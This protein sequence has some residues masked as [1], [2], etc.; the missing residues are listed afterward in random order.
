MYAINIEL[1]E[2][3]VNKNYTDGSSYFARCELQEFLANRGFP[4]TKGSM[5]CAINEMTSVKAVITIEAL[6]KEFPWLKKCAKNI[7]L[8]KIDFIEDLKLAL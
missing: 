4:F 7:S 3:E 1:D 8:V 5:H 2:L 6:S